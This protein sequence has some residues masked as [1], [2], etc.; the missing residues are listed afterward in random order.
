MAG[1][2]G[3]GDP[4]GVFGAQMPARAVGMVALLPLFRH[5][6]GADRAWAY[7]P[8]LRAERASAGL[9]AA[10]AAALEVLALHQ[11]LLIVY[12]LASLA[13]VAAAWR[14]GR[15]GIVMATAV[16]AAAAWLGGTTGRVWADASFVQLH[17]AL[18]ALL[19]QAVGFLRDGRHVLNAR[20][21]AAERELAATHSAL[22]GAQGLYTLLAEASRD[23]VFKTDLDGRVVYASP[24]VSAIA[25]TR[26][27]VVG[28]RV[29]EF[30]DPTQ[31]AMFDNRFATAMAERRDLEFDHLV[32][33]KDGVEQWFDARIHCQRDDNGAAE[34]GVVIL[35]G[36]DEK[37]ALEDELVAATLRDPL[38]GLTN[39]ATFTRM[40]AQHIGAGG[41]G[42][43]AKFDLDHFR[44]INQEHGSEVGDQVLV[45]FA[46]LLRS[47]L[48]EGD[49]IA[50]VGGE[51][52][53][54]M[55]PSATPDE[56]ERVCSRIV[57][58]MA[59][60]GAGAVTITASA[61]VSRIAATLDETM[62]NADR[63]VVVAKAKGRNRVEM[64]ER[65]GV[66]PR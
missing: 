18:T 44:T 19:A 21:R 43:L 6:L 34:G 29:V 4:F 25:G 11:P 10:A 5:L 50:R 22:R 32:F 40:L 1:A 7:R 66:F 20:L 46:N 47:L 35:S 55:L 14:G 12:F 52:F 27:A 17:L 64:D 9:F 36:L 28:R 15:M 24:A 23:V 42:C 59:E 48:R 38:T 61:G 56:A 26:D 54:V 31:A 60:I 13:A 45:S 37:K 39:R 30:I 8:L 33:H 2:A 62:K 41:S 3:G 57:S 53:A 51:R 65:R 16:L 58:E 49:V 63:A